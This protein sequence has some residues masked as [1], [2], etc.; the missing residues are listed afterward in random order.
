MTV[1]VTVTIRAKKSR[2]TPLQG[3][4][5]AESLLVKLPNDFPVDPRSTPFIGSVLK[6][7]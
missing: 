7:N 3:K 4:G 6:K 2:R 1:T 5:K